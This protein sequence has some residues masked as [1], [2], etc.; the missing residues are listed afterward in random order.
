MKMRFTMLAAFVCLLVSSLS[1]HRY[2]YQNVT[3]DEKL[4]ESWTV[5]GASTEAD[6]GFTLIY[7][8]EETVTLTKTYDDLFECPNFGAGQVQIIADGVVKVAV[9]VV[10]AEGAEYVVNSAAT[11]GNEEVEEKLAIE[12]ASFTAPATAKA[13]KV[14]VTDATKANY[15]VI[16]R[17]K[18]QSPWM[19]PQV[20]GTEGE[21]VRVEAED[22]DEGGEG[23]GFISC[24]GMGKE[25][26]Y[27]ED[28]VS[29]DGNHA[30]RIHGAGEFG[31]ASNGWAFSDGG[32]SQWN[33]SDYPADMPYDQENAEHYFGLTT[34]YT[35]NVP[36]D[37]TVNLYFRVGNAVQDI[38]GGMGI[39]SAETGL[40]DRLSEWGGFDY[41]ARYT[42]AY[43]VMLDGKSLH[44]C[45]E[46]DAMGQEGLSTQAERFGAG[47][48]T[49]TAIGNIPITVHGWSADL[50][51][52]HEGV[53]LSAGKHV[54]AY[55]SL[56]PQQV[57]DCFEIETTGSAGVKG[58][59]ADKA[60]KL[61]VYPT[62]AS[63]V[64]NIVGVDAPYAIYSLAGQLVAQ[65]NEATVNVSN[66]NKGVYLVK[67]GSEVKKFIKK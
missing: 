29:D 17:V 57:F 48:D 2:T 26:T 13:I 49:I 25:I 24:L 52:T 20:S 9:A 41:V 38:I 55:K 15:I 5:T 4:A 23:V 33:G 28:C 63:D 14:I 7:P 1:A 37:V 39:A 67:V 43:V 56:A 45:P 58:V 3:V 22:F 53:N 47:S 59:A 51:K 30:V 62:V 35:V 65:G 16:N 66:L 18:I 64:I 21:R 27:R 50:L 32:A 11:C 61:N 44:V 36:T 31:W 6:E 12:G 46:Y 54:F 8:E 42:A 34:F 40:K 60:S 19:T 10:D